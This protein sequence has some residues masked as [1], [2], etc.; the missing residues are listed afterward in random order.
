MTIIKIWRHDTSK[1]FVKI[2]GT[3]ALL[4]ATCA[5]LSLISL[6]TLDRKFLWSRWFAYIASGLLDAVLL[7]LLWFEPVS[8]SDIV[9]RTIGVLS[10]IIAA[11]T[12]LTPVFHK[13]S[14]GETAAEKIDAEI[15][16]L[17]ERIAELESKKKA[18]VHRSE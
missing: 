13:L 7:W 3:A 18:L 11:M 5:L 2:N 17:R 6:A 1:L 8:E 15:K 9:S 14:S 12:I 16:Q 4:A 10:V